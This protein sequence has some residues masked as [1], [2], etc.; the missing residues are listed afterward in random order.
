MSRSKSFGNLRLTAAAPL[1]GNRSGLGSL[2]V[3]SL[4]TINGLIIFSGV[5]GLNIRNRLITRSVGNLYNTSERN[6]PFTGNSFQSQAEMSL[7]TKTERNLAKTIENLKKA[8]NTDLSKLEAS[9]TSEVLLDTENESEH[10][11]PLA[12]STRNQK[13]KGAVQKRVERYQPRSRISRDTTSGESDSNSSEVN[14]SPLLQASGTL[15]QQFAQ[16]RYFT[17]INGSNRSISCVESIPRQS[18][19]QTRRIFEPQQRN[20]SSNIQRRVPNYLAQKLASSDIVA[21]DMGNEEYSQQSTLSNEVVAFQDFAT[22]THQSKRKC[23]QIY[24]N[25][26]VFYLS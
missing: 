23:L 16:R 6:D 9:E 8:S 14:G 10:L 11:F 12:L 15:G 25:N 4:F 3:F 21:P 1:N 20:S 24:S 13:G 19:L 22:K 2:L 17:T 5:S 26:L 7:G 18:V